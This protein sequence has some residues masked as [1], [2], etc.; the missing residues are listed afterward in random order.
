[1]AALN[2]IELYRNIDSFVP[3]L[4][5]RPQ[6]D[7]PQSKSETVL[8]RHQAEDGVS[9]PAAVEAPHA[10]VV[11]VLQEGDVQ[12]V[13]VAGDGGES[14]PGKQKIHLQGEGRGEGGGVRGEGGAAG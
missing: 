3:S 6:L 10:L 4:T 14:Q 9:N 12:E 13:E 7:G 2:S 1:M 5:F 8:V 11:Q